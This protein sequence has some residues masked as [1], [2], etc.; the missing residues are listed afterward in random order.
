MRALSILILSDGRPGHYHLSEGIAAAIARHRRINVHS[1]SLTRQKMVPARVLAG[2]LKLGA[3]PAHVLRA[4]YQ[5]DATRIPS[6]DLVISSGGDTLAANVA[7]AAMTGAPN[8]FCGTLRHFPPEAFSLVVSSYARH[9]DLPR[10]LVALKP[11]GIDPDTLARKPPAIALG[12]ANP[13]GMAGLLIGGNSG[14]FHYADSEWE[15]VISFLAKMHHACGTRWVV[16]TSRRTGDAVSDQLVALAGEPQGPIA[17]LIDYRTSGPGTLP[18]LFASVD[19][20]IVTEDSSTMI[21]EAVCAR[22]PVVGISPVDHGFKDEER[23]YRTYLREEG[24]CRFLPI[25]GL[26]PADFLDALAAVRP[27]DGNHLDRLA[28]RLRERLPALFA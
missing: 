3:Q 22:L 10:H 7:A 26:S 21:S 14:L 23:E 19:A 11:N 2:L 8:I 12:P 4:G 9:A 1:I 15:A 20:V 18:D 17:R 13:P 6:A 5:I 25:D 24:W 27:L 28:E 16:S